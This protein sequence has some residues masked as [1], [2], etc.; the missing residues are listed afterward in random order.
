[1]TYLEA[2]QGS[3]KYLFATISSQTA[4]PYIIVTGKPVMALGG[5]S[6]SDQILT[7]SQLKA[8]IREGAIKYFLLSGGSGGPGGSG[9]SALTSWIEAN[10]STVPASA[11][12]GSSSG[13]LYVVT[14]AT[15]TA[16]NS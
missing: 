10:T 5:F 7:L 6:G 1:M 15:L 3:A 12:S 2:N 16:A 8:L 9:N 11:Y 14:S 4:A 13:S